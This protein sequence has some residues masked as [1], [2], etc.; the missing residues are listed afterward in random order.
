MEKEVRLPGQRFLV[1]GSGSQHSSWPPSR[2]ILRQ[3]RLHHWLEAIPLLSRSRKIILHGFFDW[4]LALT[5][6]A[7]PWLFPRCAWIMWGGDV[8][9]DP[10]RLRVRRWIIEPMRRMAIR[11]F[12]CLV[13]YIP[14]DMD[15]VREWYGARGRAHA[16][17][18]YPS[19]LWREAHPRPARWRTAKTVVLVGNSATSTNEHAAI[20]AALIPYHQ[21]DL[22]IYCPLSYGNATYAREVAAEGKR[23]FG[24]KFTPLL[25]FM[26]GDQ[27]AGFLAAVD[28]AIFAHRRQQ[29]MGNAIS[30]LGMG[31]KVYMRREV[32]SRQLFSHLGV[33]V[34]D[35]EMGL[36]VTP[37][38]AQT[39]RANAQRIRCF[40]SPQR[41]CRQLRALCR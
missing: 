26:P 27:Y 17:L 9:K 16:C 24:D 5:L 19:N 22:H 21:R 18:M 23:L 37:L 12:G 14:G 8:Y 4:R 41:L 2:H 39:A 7:Q 29:A 31:K 34:H 32:T 38:D 10:R 25:D 11:R 3:K 15:W 30:L 35:L 1:H 36:D 20:F 6:A 28:V 13:T 40:F 33:V